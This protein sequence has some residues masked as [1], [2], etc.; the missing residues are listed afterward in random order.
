MYFKASPFIKTMKNLFYII[1][2]SF[3]LIGCSSTQAPIPAPKPFEA[4]RVTPYKPGAYP[5]GQKPYYRISKSMQCV[6]YAREASGI[7]IYGNAHTWWGQAKD[8]YPRSSRPSV[9]AVM[10]LS[11]TSRLRYGHLAVVTRVIDSR[12][13]E[14]EHVNWGGDKKTRRIVYKS[15]PVKD[16]SKFNDWSQARFWNYPSKSYGSVYAVS[17][18]ILP[19]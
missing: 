1:F 9:G 6:P 16:S 11:K 4:K 17:G 8:K 12:N 13:I 3:L 10:V 5:P 18:F 19:N 2:I 15:M 14:V 7:P